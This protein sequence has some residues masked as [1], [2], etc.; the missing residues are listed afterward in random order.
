[1][2]LL[3]DA[4]KDPGALQNKAAPFFDERKE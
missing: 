3:R 4:K 1:M 2:I